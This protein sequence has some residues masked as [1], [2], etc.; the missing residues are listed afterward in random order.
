MIKLFP[1]SKRPWSDAPSSFVQDYRNPYEIYFG[2][3]GGGGDDGGDT[4]VGGGQIG[5]DDF[6]DEDA[7]LM[8]G[9]DDTNET[10]NESVSGGGASDGYGD[11]DFGQDDPASD[12]TAGAGPSGPDGGMNEGQ[13]NTGISDAA[14]IN[15]AVSDALDAAVS[16]AIG[17][18]SADDTS[19]DLGDTLGFAGYSGDDVEESYGLMD[20]VTDTP[21]TTSNQQAVNA[22]FVTNLAGKPIGT[23]VPGSYVTQANATPD[24]IAAAYAALSGIPGTAEYAAAQEAQA[25]QLAADQE[26][27]FMSDV[28]DLDLEPEVEIDPF[29]LQTMPAIGTPTNVGMTVQTA[30]G[31]M[32]VPEI[33]MSLANQTGLSGT[34][35][36]A[37]QSAIADNLAGFSSA[38]S[39]PSNVDP[40]YSQSTVD[41]LSNMYGI[42]YG[43]LDAAVDDDFADIGNRPGPGV[44]GPGTGYTDQGLPVGLEFATNPQTGAQI[45]T[46]LAGLTEQQQAN[47]PFSMDVAQFIGSS[48]YGYEIDPATGNPIG[49]VGT[50]PFGILGALTT[51]LQQLFNGP[52][53]TVQDLIE[54][55]AYTGMTGQ[56]NDG[57]GAGGGE[58]GNVM[59][60]ATQVDP[61]PAGYEMDP[62]TNQCVPIDVVAPFQLGKRQY[63]PTEMPSLLGTPVG[64]FQSQLRPTTPDM[65]FM[66]PAVNPFGF[67]RG[68]IVELPK[69]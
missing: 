37:V 28:L 63:A 34:N 36:A 31:P 11:G 3:F 14:G 6:A 47:Q 66:R 68:G 44:E 45:T 10:G 48:P 51:G 53:E 19:T 65:S 39:A 56:D 59:Q 69:R 67:A 5:A 26:F 52:P 22:G 50:A 42:D 40:N 24:E 57:I 8:D 46:N 33:N 25:A 9:P 49:Q 18:Y 2:L 21:D 61:C 29:A 43:L 35:L 7:G 60:Q 15:D 27:G 62:A 41:Q 16:D 64:P 38:P 20:A 4:G 32:S 17:D 54:Q 1:E 13:D 12:A 30:Y 55:G 58:G 23:N